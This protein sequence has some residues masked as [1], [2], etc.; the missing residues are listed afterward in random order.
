MSLQSKAII[1]AFLGILSIVSYFVF[2]QQSEF[3]RFFLPKVFTIKKQE[4]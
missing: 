1:S 2:I 4:L 3:T